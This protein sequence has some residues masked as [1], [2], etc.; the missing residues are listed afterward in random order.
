MQT[1]NT[2]QMNRGPSVKRYA[3]ADVT[4]SRL[5]S[6]SMI[7]IPWFIFVF[8]CL[9]FAFMYH[10]YPLLVWF[11]VFFVAIPLAMGSRSKVRKQ[12]ASMYWIALLGLIALITSTMAGIGAYDFKLRAYWFYNDSWFYTNVLPSDPAG[13]Y[14][15]AGKIIFADEVKLDFAHS[16][17]YKDDTIYCVAPVMDDS[18]HTGQVQFWAAGTDCCG[19]RGGFVCDDSWDSQARSGLVLGHDSHS[20]L[21]GDMRGQYL[22]AIKQAEAAFGISS[23]KEPILVRW[24]VDPDKMTRNLWSSGFGIVLV[25]TAVCLL[26]LCAFSSMLQTGFKGLA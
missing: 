17:G 6:F 13:A 16:L 14:I 26:L 5:E 4:F 18:G 8:N 22:A 20:H 15:D 2:I 24:V 9:L 7:S 19:Q 10:R 21:Q 1:M 11:E 23:A 12:S 25:S 3:H